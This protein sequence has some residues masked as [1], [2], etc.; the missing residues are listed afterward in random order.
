MKLDYELSK[1]AINDL[2][3]IWSYTAKEWS[4][5]QANKYYEIIFDVIDSIC[6][7]PE[8]GRSIREVKENHRLKIAHSHMIIYKIENEKIL[9]D[10]ILP[11]KMDVENKLAE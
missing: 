2:E 9:I 1:L 8:I 11:Q 4:V 7:D 5:K 10:S 6:T 3:S